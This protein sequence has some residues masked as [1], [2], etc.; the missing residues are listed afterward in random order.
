MDEFVKCSGAQWWCDVC[1]PPYN[2]GGSW[3][4]ARHCSGVKHR[5]AADGQRGRRADLHANVAA[6]A[7]PAASQQPEAHLLQPPAVVL[8][9]PLPLLPPPPPFD[10]LPI[11]AYEPVAI[12]DAKQSNGT[13]AMSS[14]ATNGKTCEI[15]SVLNT[16]SVSV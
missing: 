7:P 13:P 10:H 3:N 12:P 9:P 2:K 11:M 5:K 16:C 15:A 4:G 6:A 14:N 8:L 1:P